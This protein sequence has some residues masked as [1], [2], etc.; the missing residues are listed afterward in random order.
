MK[1]LTTNGGADELEGIAREL[2]ALANA[3]RLGL[4]RFLEEPQHI[5]DV[6]A[7]L[8]LA[9]QTAQRHVDQLVEIGAVTRVQVRRG[10]GAANHFVVVPQQLFLIHEK[11]GKLCGAEPRLQ[12]QET[13][14]PVT[15]PMLTGMEE[16]AEARVAP[17]LTIV[18]GLRV[19]HLTPLVGEGPW[20]IGREPN[21]S[22]CLD[23]DPFVSTRHAEVRRTE[24][25]FEAADLYSSNGTVLD[26][27]PMARGGRGDLQSGAIL[28]VGRSILVFRMPV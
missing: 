11:L 26:W 21:A 7:E 12:G 9:R 20:L 15:T 16:H 6:A 8:K 23:Y 24:A 28:R 5:E 13:V 25:G 17:T 1:A 2:R 19:G 4:L 18:H 10:M 14:R 27:Q 3:K 22:V